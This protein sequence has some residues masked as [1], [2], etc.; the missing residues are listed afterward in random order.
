MLLYRSTI[1]I[2]Q[3]QAVQALYKSLSP[4]WLAIID[5][6]LI[7]FCNKYSKIMVMFIVSLVREVE[8]VIRLMIGLLL[9]LCMMRVVSDMFFVVWARLQ[10]LSFPLV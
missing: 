9:N 3:M 2:S 8:L 6:K 1:Q 4:N 5:Q 7:Y 10:Q